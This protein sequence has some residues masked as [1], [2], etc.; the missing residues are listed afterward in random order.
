MR[1]VDGVGLQIFRAT[2]GA[3][4]DAITAKSIGKLEQT[5]GAALAAGVDPAPGV[6]NFMTMLGGTGIV[7]DQQLAALG[8]LGKMLT[9]TTAS[10][11]FLDLAISPKEKALQVIADELYKAYRADDALQ[12]TA[13][14]D[15]IKV[16]GTDDRPEI[17]VLFRWN[18]RRDN[19][20]TA[21]GMLGQKIRDIVAAHPELKD[22]LS[23]IDLVSLLGQQTSM[24]EATPGSEPAEPPQELLRVGLNF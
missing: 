19:A 7:P 17:G 6:A 15:D 10:Q 23:G 14:I 18:V 3:E 21:I 9:T 20:G 8:D 2:R 12:Q 22:T 5:I 24:L 16:G 11:A 1:T 13:M 4:P